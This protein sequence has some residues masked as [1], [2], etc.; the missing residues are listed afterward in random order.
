MAEWKRVKISDILNRSRIPVDI[1][2]DHTYKRVTIRINHKGVSLRDEAIG[3]KIGTKKQFVLK[4]GQFIL[5]KIDARYGAFGIAPPEVDGAIIT[6]NFWAYDFDR[7]IVTAEW[8]NNYTNSTAFYD[9]C[10]R[11]SSGITHRKYLDEKIFLN[12]ELSL[13]PVEEQHNILQKFDRQKQLI[14]GLYSLIAKDAAN[15]AKLR[16]TLLQEAIEGKLTADWRKQN[17]KLISSDNHASK[18]LEKIRTEKD[19]LISGGR[20]RREE[21]QEPTYSFPISLPDE[22]ASCRVIDISKQVTDGT[23][24]TPTYVK[25]GMTFL[26]AQNVK[27]FRFIPENHQFVS[28]HA[29]EACRKSKVPE[30]GDLLVARVGAGIGEAAVIDQDIEFAFYVSLGLIK[31][32]NQFTD[33]RYLAIVFNSPYGVSYSKGNTSSGGTSAGNY[34]LGRIRALEIPFPSLM[35][36]RAIVERV[37]HFLNIIKEL[38]SQITERKDKSELLMQ[39]VL[40]EAFEHNHV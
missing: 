10:E 4:S 35:E 17:P 8:I 2:N 20:I 31:V 12:H 28:K 33:S 11:A 24:Q 22:W 19:R 25:D 7:T 38:N 39:S 26:S 40:R 36:Q 6:G 16:Q 18:L 14:V 9:I 29:F 1:R 15:L 21:T 23:H 5:S 30:K 27:P 3:K 32:F 13:P 37:E 34:N